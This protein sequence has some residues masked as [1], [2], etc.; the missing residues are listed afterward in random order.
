MVVETPLMKIAD[1]LASL[2][3]NLETRTESRGSSTN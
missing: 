1:Q 3:Q 2:N